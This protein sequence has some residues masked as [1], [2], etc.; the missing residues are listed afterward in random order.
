MI[1]LMK[2]HIFMINFC[3][4][5][6][7]KLEKIKNLHININDEI[8]IYIR[9]MPHWAFGR[10]PVSNPGIGYLWH[11]QFSYILLPVALCRR[12]F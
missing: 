2:E 7:P 1:K 6:D 3:I 12:F 9:A 10:P 11:F 5:N 4:A 8:G